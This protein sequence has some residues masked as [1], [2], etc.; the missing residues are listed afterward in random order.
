[1]RLSILRM[2]PQRYVIPLTGPVGY[3]N[4]LMPLSRWT[5]SINFEGTSV[6]FH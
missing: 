1:M 3:R 6:G 4:G 2:A 5:E